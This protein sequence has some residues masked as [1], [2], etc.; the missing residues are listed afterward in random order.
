MR[1]K[2]KFLLEF[3]KTQIFLSLRECVK[4]KKDLRDCMIEY[5]GTAPGG[6]IIRIGDDLG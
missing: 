2:Q 5:Q 4:A 6:L 1:E 3:V